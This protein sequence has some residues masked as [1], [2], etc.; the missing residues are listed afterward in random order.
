MTGVPA[1]ALVADWPVGHAAVA[2]VTPAGV[3]DAVGARNE[4]FPLAS[5]T[6]LFTAWA[7][8]VAIDEGACA[9][10]DPVGPPGSTLRHLLAHASGLP[11][12]G[13]EPI[14][15]PATRRIYSNEG[16]E[17]IGAHVARTTGFDFWSYVQEGVCD[18][19][20]MRNVTLSGSPAHG[21]S[22]TLDDLC[23]FAM[24]CFA[25]RVL[26]PSTFAAAVTVEFAG[27]DGVVP[28]FGRQ[29][30]CDWGLGPE[31]KGTK[32]PHWTGH[33]N[34]AATYG[35]FGRSGALLWVDPVACVA[36]VSVCDTPFGEWAAIAW[37]KLADA[38]L[39]DLGVPSR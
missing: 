29:Q 33:R 36:L 19:I 28:G 11:F 32:N 16:Y 26:A 10:D 21:A 8:L 12:E 39:E 30:P 14:A 25:P 5:V 1:L 20:G 4:R 31:L 35:H 37:P 13:N 38:V 24:E 15:A 18:P 9:L 17:L 34:T 3:L 22:A 7:P 27:L 6:K 2:V 23:A